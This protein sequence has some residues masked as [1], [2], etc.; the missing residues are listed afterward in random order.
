MSDNS[1]S[2]ARLPVLVHRG[3]VIDAAQGEDQLLPLLLGAVL[4]R[5]REAPG[6]LGQVPSAPPTLADG[7]RS[8]VL[9]VSEAADTLGISTSL[10]YRLV[11]RGELPSVRLGRRLVV[12]R[13]AIDRVLAMAVARAEGPHMP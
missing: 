2:P 12:P 9:S 6:T 7:A 11:G 10:A 5:L 13:A 3:Q 1:G 8:A 4:E